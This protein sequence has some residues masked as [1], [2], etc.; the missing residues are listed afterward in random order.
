MF[1]VT[2]KLRKEQEEDS[3]LDK[4]LIKQQN[5][6]EELDERLIIGKQRYI[7]ATKNLNENVSAYELLENMRNQRNINRLVYNNLRDTYEQ[8]GKFEINEKRQ[9]LK[10]LEEIISMPEISRD[11]INK[12][13][14]EI[15]NTQ[16]NIDRLEN[17]LKQSSSKSSELTVYKQNALN[18]SNLKDSAQKIFKKLEDEK[19]LLERKYA[20]LEKKFE[21]T[22]GH[23]FV[24]KDDLIQKAENMKKKKEIF[25]K[26]SKILD[27]FTG[28]SLVLD[29][30]IKILKTKSD[31]YE[32]IL[33]RVEEKQGVSGYKNAKK[34]LEELAKR[35]NEI[36]QSKALTLEEY[37]KLILQFQQK[38]KDSQD[39]HAPHLDK[40]NK[41]KSEYETLL[42][43]YNQ[44]KNSYEMSIS[45]FQ[46]QYNKSKEEFLKLEADYKI[47]QNK[48]H[49]LHL[50]IKYNDEMVKRYEAENYYMSKPDKK[51]NDKYKSYSEYYKAFISEQENYLKDLKQQQSDIKSNYDDNLRQVKKE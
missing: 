22:K 41:I 19:N 46:T 18:A 48:Y 10:S 5:D 9:K 12:I 43:T 42:P 36:D 35:K 20:D 25:V 1:E 38:I 30:T 34:E 40:L 33:Q 32:S 8:L 37:S 16:N 11:E 27:A 51:L 28:E 50:N 31:D 3:N 26:F 47:S 4:K 29:K 24:R 7:D 45:D 44:K 23:K 14:T 6:L 21:S 17:K 39:K 15:K 49:S 2:S 13:K